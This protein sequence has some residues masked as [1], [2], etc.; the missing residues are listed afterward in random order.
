MKPGKDFIG[1]GAFGLIFN[2]KGQFLLIRTRPS[3]KK[4]KDY[5]NI[6]SMPGGTI[7]FGETVGEALAREIR[8]ETGLEISAPSL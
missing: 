3:D 4:S 6:W 1:I 5:D 8:E 7:E 2:E